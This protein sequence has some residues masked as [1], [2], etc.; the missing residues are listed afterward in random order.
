VEFGEGTG[1]MTH[2]GRVELT[3]NHCTRVSATREITFRD[4]TMTA[5]TANT[6]EVTFSY[7]IGALSVVDDATLIDSPFI[8]TG[9]TGRFDGASG[10]GT[11]HGE[12]PGAK[13]VDLLGGTPFATTLTGAVTY[14]PGRGGR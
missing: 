2:G 12:A 11:M 8:V 3:W 9:G 4:G 1:E 14:A 7:G 10:G 6:D 5:V 13:P